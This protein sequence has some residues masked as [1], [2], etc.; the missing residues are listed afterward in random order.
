MAAQK[1]TLSFLTLVLPTF[2]YLFPKACWL[3]SLLLQDVGREADDRQEP[4]IV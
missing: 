4:G 2:I 3:Y 1:G